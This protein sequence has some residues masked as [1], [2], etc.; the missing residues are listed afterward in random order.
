MSAEKRHCAYVI[1]GENP[2]DGEAPCVYAF[3]TEDELL[4]FWDGVEAASGWLDYHPCDNENY[5]WSEELR[6]V[7]EVKP[8]GPSPEEGG[9][10][11]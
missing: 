9:Q 8:S 1:W 2:E 5:K 11:T 10:Q 4:A 6:E 7:V 3:K